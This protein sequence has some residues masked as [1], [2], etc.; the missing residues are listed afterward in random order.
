[1]QAPMNKTELVQSVLT[2]AEKQ[3]PAA[4]HCCT[5]PPTCQMW[6]LKLPLRRDVQAQHH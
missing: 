2:S 4:S 5:E 3:M 6:T 1:M